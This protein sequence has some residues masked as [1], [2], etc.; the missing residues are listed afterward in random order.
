MIVAEGT[1]GFGTPDVKHLPLSVSQNLWMSDPKV[2]DKLI[3]RTATAPT[4]E[5]AA[6]AA[7]SSLA[8]DQAALAAKRQKTLLAG[9]VVVGLLAAGAYFF[10]KRNVAQQN[11]FE[12]DTPDIKGSE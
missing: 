8:A 11:A 6:S 10:R 9:G 1:S 2:R 4:A 12:H 7:A 3:R 5:A